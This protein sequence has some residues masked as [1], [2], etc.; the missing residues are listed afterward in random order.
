MSSDEGPDPR[1]GEDDNADGALASKVSRGA[2]GRAAVTGVR[3]MT[4][5]SLFNQA[6][7][8]VMNFVLVWF[9]TKGEFGLMAVAMIVIT[10]IDRLANLGTGQAVIQRENLDRRTTDAVFTLNALIG[11][12]LAATIFVCAGPLAVLAGGDE[13]RD[14]DDLLRVLAI[15]VLVKSIG[16]V[17][18]GLMRRNLRFRQAAMAMSAG[19]VTY[20]VVAVT[21]A[22]LDVGPMSIALGSTCAS[23]MATSLNWIWGRYR[24][25]LKFD[26]A[27]IKPIVGFSMGL[28]ATNIFNFLT[29][30]LDRSL[31]AHML[32][33]ESLGLYQLGVRTLRTP[34]IT[35]TATVNQVLM[36]T[37]ARLQD[38]LPEQRRR[39]LQAT[40]GTALL[41]YP[42]MSGLAVVAVP[43]IDVALPDGW[44]DAS[45]VVSLMALVGMQ[46]TLLGLV[47][48]VFV[49][50]ARTG[51]Q[52]S[53]NMALGGT[54]IASYFL[55][56]RHSIEAVVIGIGIVHIFMVPVV[57]KLTFRIIDLTFREYFRTLAPTFA[58][59]A[60]MAG[61]VYG[62]RYLLEQQGT[63]SAVVLACC[64][65]TGALV[66]VGLLAVFRPTGIDELASI[67]GIRRPK[68]AS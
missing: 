13:G 10:L 36:P 7:R 16:V 38:D 67:A 29:Q 14:A 60:V 4:G 68:Q 57:L 12:T 45:T 11:L 32:G 47:S 18:M 35:L 59:T 49:A 24:P 21:A 8:T 20:L 41:A 44:S 46:R 31:V 65:F 26:W 55:T 5:A 54:L 15:S 63:A 22:A 56:A 64:V 27:A 50:N 66:Y 17:H 28:T 39:F 58:I 33:T 34:I 25:S 9:L 40:A 30:N 51:T 62:V 43:L 48:P 42:L 52:L 23:A 6:V 37:L 19:T 61:S 2:Q 53:S 1:V 3:W